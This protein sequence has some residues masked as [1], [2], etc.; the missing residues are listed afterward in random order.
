MHQVKRITRKDQIKTNKTGAHHGGNC[1]NSSDC[2]NWKWFKRPPQKRCNR[3]AEKEFEALRNLVLGNAVSSSA[4]KGG[5]KRGGKKNCLLSV[6]SLRWSNRH[7][8][9]LQRPDNSIINAS[10]AYS[11]PTP[12]HDGSLW[13]ESLLGWWQTEL[14]EARTEMSWCL[15]LLLLLFRWIFSITLIISLTLAA[16]WISIQS[17]VPPPFFLKVWCVKLVKLFLYW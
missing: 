1:A 15:A 9:R 12:A 14:P 5:K 8:R 2:W 13:G 6:F 11:L 10:P 4:R 3:Q 16:T 17:L 7:D